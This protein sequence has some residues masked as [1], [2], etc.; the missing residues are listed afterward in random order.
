MINQKLEI[1]IRKFVVDCFLSKQDRN[2][3][4]TI[5]H[6]DLIDNLNTGKL[7]L[8]LTNLTGVENSIL[9]PIIIDELTAIAEI[10]QRER[11]LNKLN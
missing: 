5:Q 7:N 2:Q 8:N 3:A 11:E 9:K 6:K 10:L 1:A 4:G